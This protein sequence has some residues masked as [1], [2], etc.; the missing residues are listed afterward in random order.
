MPDRP[1]LGPGCFSCYNEIPHKFAAD[2]GLDLCCH[3][4]RLERLL[5][6]EEAAIR[7]GIMRTATKSSCWDANIQFNF[8]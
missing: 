5:F 8:C 3:R 4:N 1:L 2:E 6:A 7:Q